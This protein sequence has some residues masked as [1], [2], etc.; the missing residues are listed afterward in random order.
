MSGEMSARV[1]TPEEIVQWVM[2][3]GARGWAPAAL[4]HLLLAICT[5]G[6]VRYCEAR[7]AAAKLS[8]HTIYAEEIRKLA[9]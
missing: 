6:D 7:D 2:A 4:E 5:H 3:R 8:E 1:E 9:P